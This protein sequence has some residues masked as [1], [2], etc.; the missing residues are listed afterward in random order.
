MY[1]SAKIAQIG[2]NFDFYSK[3]FSIFV[4]VKCVSV[5]VMYNEIMIFYG[6][7]VSF[8][9]NFVICFSSHSGRNVCY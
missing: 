3:K 2:A 6:T 1:A 4:L 8:F 5:L 9:F 7:S